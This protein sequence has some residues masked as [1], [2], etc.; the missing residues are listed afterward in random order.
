MPRKS[1]NPRLK[2]LT[3][4]EQEILFNLAKFQYLQAPQLTKLGVSKSESY[5]RKRANALSKGSKPL[6][7]IIEDGPNSKAIRRHNIYHL[8]AHGGKALKDVLE[9]KNVLYPRQYNVDFSKQYFHRVYSINFFISLEVWAKN[10]GYEIEDF[11]YYFR[12]TGTNRNNRGGKDL[13]EN[14]LD[15]EKDGVGYI[16][17]DGIFLA[18]RGENKPIFGLFEQHNGKDTGR[19]IEQI[20]SHCIALRHGIPSMRLDVKYDGNY[21]ANR[22]FICFEKKGCMRATMKRLASASDFEGF[23]PY[24]H[25][26]CIEDENPFLSESWVYADGKAVEI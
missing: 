9:G 12:Q 10:K 11:Q 14:R 3:D 8:T 23:M 25:F 15:I 4:V 19:I 6:L 13:S 18:H 17:P 24:F 1:T 2:I 21:I 26:A 5:I 16:V 22:V 7:K 20:K